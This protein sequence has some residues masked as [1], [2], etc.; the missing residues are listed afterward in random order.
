M[1]I[2]ALCGLCGSGKDSVAEVLVRDHGFVRFSFA[3]KLKDV[4]AAI[5]GWDRDMLEGGSEASRA[6]RE[7]EDRWWAER[8]SRPGLTP[9]LVLQEIGTDALRRWNDDIWIAAAERQLAGMVAGRNV[10]ISDCR[11][12]NER[13]LIR[14][15]GGIVVQVRRGESPPWLTDLLSEGTLPRQDQAH[16]SEWAWALDGWDAVLENDG[17]I[18]DLPGKVAALLRDTLRDR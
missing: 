10:V 3:S 15:L 6:W 7:Q 17:R 2:I 11:F 1:M 18:A 14:A 13:A 12:P 8:L 5:F 4:V 9:R 16:I